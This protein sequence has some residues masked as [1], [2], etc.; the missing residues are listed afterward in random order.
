M[1]TTVR[2]LHFF[3]LHW[4]HYRFFYLVERT[5]KTA[6]IFMIIVT[7]KGFFGVFQTTTKRPQKA[8]ER[9]QNAEKRLQNDHKSRKSDI[10]KRASET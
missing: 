4:T 6:L 2:L 1:P 8:T 7:Q 3:V 5:P 10:R 9:P